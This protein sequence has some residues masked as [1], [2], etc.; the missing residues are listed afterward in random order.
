MK[1][2]LL[3]FIACLWLNRLSAQHQVSANQQQLM[4]MEEHMHKYAYDIVNAPELVDRLR[5]DS[6]FTRSLVQALKVPY[7]FSYHFDSLGTISVLY[8]PDSSFRIFTWQLM[9]DLSYYRQKGAIQMHTKDGSLQLIPLFDFSEFTDNPV[10]SVRDN[11]HWVGAVYYN[12]IQKKY[13]NKNYYTLLGYDENDARSTKKWIEVLTFD[14]NNKPQFGGLYFNYPNDPIK[15]P[16][17]AYRFCLEFKKDANAKMNY[18]PELG[19]ITFA[20]L[21]SETGEPAAKYTLVPIGN[22]EGFKWVNGKWIYMPVITQL[23]SRPNINP[24]KENTDQPKNLFPAA[25]KKGKNSQ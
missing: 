7:S 18:D 3:A 1:Y 17:P 21:V 24:Q 25:P 8:A 9:R 12:I 4:E 23:D 22:Y 20:S 2:V 14:A 11:Q 13:N 10:D 5:A 6:S 15:P 19:L 16:Q